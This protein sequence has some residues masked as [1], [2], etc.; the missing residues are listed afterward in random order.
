MSSRYG[1]VEVIVV[2]TNN[3]RRIASHGYNNWKDFYPPAGESFKIQD[4]LNARATARSDGTLAVNA[5]GKVDGSEGMNHILWDLEYGF[6]Q[7]KNPAD[8]ELFRGN[9]GVYN[10]IKK[11]QGEQELDDYIVPDIPSVSK[12]QI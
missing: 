10:G 9:P 4:I 5:D 7:L 1:G 11:H 6:T 3:P 12:P 2:S 8:V